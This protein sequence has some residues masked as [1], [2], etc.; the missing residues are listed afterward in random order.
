MNAMAFPRVLAI[1]RRAVGTLDVRKVRRASA[2]AVR[3]TDRN[4]SDGWDVAE[5]HAMRRR[6]M[7]AVRYYSQRRL[8]NA[9]ARLNRGAAGIEP[10]FMKAK[11]GAKR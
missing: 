2:V 4:R 10:G 3:W 1:M 9:R 5:Y 6:A 8:N 7:R 11:K